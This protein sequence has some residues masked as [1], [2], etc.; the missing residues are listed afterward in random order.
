MGSRAEVVALRV[1]VLIL[2]AAVAGLILKGMEEPVR[3]EEGEE[4]QRSERV[5]RMETPSLER[6]VLPD[7][8]DL[9]EYVPYE[10]QISEYNPYDIEGYGFKD[11][12]KPLVSSE[13]EPEFKPEPRQP[14]RPTLQLTGII[15]NHSCPSE[16]VAILADPEYPKRIVSCKEGEAVSLGDLGAGD[17]LVVKTILP[18]GVMLNHGDGEFTLSLREDAA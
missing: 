1:S 6:A 18:D 4:A 17:R 5:L 8:Q 15:W 3:P 14:Q 9:P 2:I 10:T 7:V 11:P 12:M 16:S 13:P